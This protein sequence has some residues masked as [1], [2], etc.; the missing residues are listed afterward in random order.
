[1]N[2]EMSYL[3]CR[4]QTAMFTIGKVFKNEFRKNKPVVLTTGYDKVYKAVD[5]KM[6]FIV[7]SPNLK[8]K[9]KKSVQEAIEYKKEPRQI[10]A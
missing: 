1:M 9:S 8:P 3:L 7:K 5:K 2:N 4:L 10:T 6:V